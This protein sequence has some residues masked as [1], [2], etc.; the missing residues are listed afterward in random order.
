[1]KEQCLCANYDNRQQLEKLQGYLGHMPTMEEHYGLQD[2]LQETQKQ[3][4]QLAKELKA[5]DYE[6]DLLKQTMK[7]KVELNFSG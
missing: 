4:A 3:K 1:M 5:R 2:Q 6:L 7:E